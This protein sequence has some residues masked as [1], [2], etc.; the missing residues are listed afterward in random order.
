[1][2]RALLLVMIASSVAL[3][4]PQQHKPSPQPRGGMQ[5]YETRYYL[6]HTDLD[7][8]KAREAAIRMT[9]MA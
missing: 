5:K 2:R 6:L 9:K 4:Q 1:M 3:A 8:D 7:T